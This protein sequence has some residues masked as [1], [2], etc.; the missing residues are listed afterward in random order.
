MLPEAVKSM[1]HFWFRAQILRYMWV[2]QEATQG[3]TE[4]LRHS[5]QAGSDFFSQHAVIGVH[6]R[7]GDS[8]HAEEGLSCH[9]LGKYM[10]AVQALSK[11]YGATRVFLATDDEEVASTAAREYPQFQFATA[12]I[13]R[14]RYNN[15][16]FIGRRLATGEFAETSEGL[17]VI[18]EV[19]LLSQ[20]DFFV[21]QFTSN[22]ARVAYMLMAT[23]LGYLPPFV[24]LDVPMCTAWSHT[25]TWGKNHTYVC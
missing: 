17:D 24:S 19:T 9:A 15:T 11:Q 16:V 13:D 3:H 1:G 21:G 2:P 14:L 20:S 18:S 5:M 23:R 4:A 25:I 6:V 12:S 22:L 8:C 7:R 10:D